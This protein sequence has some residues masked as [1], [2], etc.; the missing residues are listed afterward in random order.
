[1]RKETKEEDHNDSEGESQKYRCATSLGCRQH[2]DQR[3]KLEGSS[4][5]KVTEF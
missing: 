5:M 1:M 2:P 4:N 3:G